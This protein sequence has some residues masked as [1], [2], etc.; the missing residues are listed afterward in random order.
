MRELPKYGIHVHCLKDNR[1]CHAKLLIVDR[2]AAI[3]GSHNLSV[4]ACHNNFEVS[5]IILDNFMVDIVYTAF[6]EAWSGSS[7]A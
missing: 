6:S 5:Y 7:A 2:H 1:C 4:K 3:L